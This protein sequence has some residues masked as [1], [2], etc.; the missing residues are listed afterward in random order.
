MSALAE[1]ETGRRIPLYVGDG[2]DPMRPK[3]RTA[4]EECAHVMRS[5]ILNDRYIEGLKRHGFHS[6][7]GLARL[8]EYMLGWSATS[9]SMEDWMY[10]EFARKYILDDENRQWMSDENPYSLME[11]VQNLLETIERG[12]W[13]ADEEMKKKLKEA[14]IETEERLEEV[15]DR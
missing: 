14:F 10:D 6:I 13:D 5:K 3:V 2:A 7:T 1:A 8:S 15:N 12:L 9:D 4:T 11:I